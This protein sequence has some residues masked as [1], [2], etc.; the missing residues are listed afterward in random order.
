MNIDVPMVPLG[1][2]IWLWRQHQPTEHELRGFAAR[3][4]AA[5]KIRAFEDGFGRLET[6]SPREQW[7]ALLQTAT[8]DLATART[9]EPH[10]DALT[11]LAES[12]HEQQN[13]ANLW[14]VYAAE[15][16]G[17]KLVAAGSPDIRL[18]GE[19]PW[20]SLAGELTHAL[21]TAW[22][23][24]QRQMFAVQLSHPSVTVVEQPWQSAGLS[25]IPS[26]PIRCANT[27]A[28]PVGEPGWYLQRPGFW[29]G[30]IRVAA[31]WLGGAIG[32][33]RIAADR[34]ATR[35]QPEPQRNMLLGQ[36]DAQI[37]TGITALDHAATL[38][39][40]TREFT[41]EEVQQLALRVRNS[42]YRACQAIQELSRELAGPEVLT[43]NQQF[44]KI[45]ADLTV[46]MSQ[47]HGVRDEATLGQLLVKSATP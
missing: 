19:K 28:Q 26:G 22:V 29:W 42:I 17:T 10:L 40:T 9:I 11:I 39:Q 36:I 32:L 47:H 16:A 41:A 24:E 20:C 1:E 12:G 37:Y 7:Q 43:Q 27:P 23:G 14:G 38:A 46:Y 33:A 45:D 30:A 2:W 3:N 21:V 25:E 31:C 15:A 6:A 13:T 44:N 34:H 5:S 4:T 18:T 8:I 35:T